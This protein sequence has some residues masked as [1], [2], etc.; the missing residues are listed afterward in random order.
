MRGRRPGRGLSTM[1]GRV[2]ELGDLAYVLAE[3]AD[4]R[5]RAQ[6]PG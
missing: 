3:L 2:G 1:A 4:Q 5:A 6:V